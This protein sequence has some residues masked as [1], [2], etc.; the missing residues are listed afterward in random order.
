M[1]KKS[2]SSSVVLL[3]LFII[4][5]AGSLY[6]YNSKMFERNL[7]N[8]QFV[9]DGYWNMKSPLKIKIDDESGI[10]SYKIYIKS[11]NNS[12]KVLFDETFLPPKK[13][14][15][16]DF[17]PTREIFSLKTDSI[18]VVIEATDAS[19][20]NFFRGNTIIKAY[21][22][23]IDKRR[24]LVSVV[25]N[26]YGIR[27]GG[28]ALVVFKAT[29][30]NMED[31]YIESNNKKFKVEPF[32]K[33]GY[34][35]SLLAWPIKDKNFRA[36]I[37]AK[38]RA[39]NVAKAHVPLFL[40]GKKYKLSKIKLKDSFLNGTIANLSDVFEETQGIDDK[41]ER[42]KMI[43]EK[44][45]AKNEA[46]ITKITSEV[47]TE[48]TSSFNIHRMHP[49]RGAKKVASF[50]DHRIYFYDG[51]QVSQAYHMGIDLASYKMAD[52]VSQNGGTVVFAGDNG[53]YG[54]ML[55]ISHGL[56]LYTIYGHCSS[57]NVDVGEKVKLDSKIANTGKSGYAMGD[58]L[59]FGVVVQGVE[60]RPAEWEDRN[61]IKLNITNIIK[62]SKK[63]IDRE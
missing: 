18:R 22:L 23:K 45:R 37:I 4:L 21:D 34:Y 25:D 28:V 51:K 6:V 47:P 54:N 62:N 40:K 7:P 10:K 31:L 17:K 42:F 44:V 41:I 14:I 8:I 50:G 5:I 58:H 12:D 33:D 3:G 49:L 56:G 60:V 30:K 53:L 59:H 55:A 38:D 27:L 9:N 63:L 48:M 43:N 46:F 15:D 19:R 24:P 61:W 26:S 52:I 57:F 29:D 36:T 35:V 13:S 39:G 11:S 20:W 1:N 2:S 32:Y 16:L